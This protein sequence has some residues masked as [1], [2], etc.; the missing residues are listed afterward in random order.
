MPEV[1]HRAGKNRRKAKTRK[2]AHHWH[3][4]RLKPIAPG[5]SLTVL[6]A[7][8]LFTDWKQRHRVHDEAFN[9][10]VRAI[11][12]LVVPGENDFPPSFHVMKQ[13]LE[14][15]DADDYERHLCT[16]ARVF[17]DLKKSEYKANM[18]ATCAECGA[19]R[20][21]V[22]PNGVPTPRKRFWDFRAPELVEE[23]YMDKTFAEAVG[24]CR[25]SKDDSTFHGS[26]YGKQ[27]NKMCSQVFTNPTAN[28]AYFS[29][30]GDAGQIFSI[31]IHSTT[32]IGLR[33]DASLDLDSSWD[34]HM[35]MA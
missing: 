25:D 10:L 31:R 23:F 33:Y 20:F 27:L 35:S 32:I 29:L 12:E 7:A 24:T 18:S 4:Q 1:M 15:Q 11:S 16:C 9:D 13:V 6:K 28:A 21:T 5:H 22:G 17:P 30:G 3:T 2:T 34:W 19:K 8:Y 14:T 26:S